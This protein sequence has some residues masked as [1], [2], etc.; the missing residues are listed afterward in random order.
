M[1]WIL[2]WFFKPLEWSL[3]PT[4]SWVI[5]ALHSSAAFMPCHSPSHSRQPFSSLKM[6]FFLPT[7]WPCY[8]SLECSLHLLLPN[9]ISFTCKGGVW[10]Q[11]QWTTLTPWVNFNS[12]KY[13]SSSPN[14]FTV[15]CGHVTRRRSWFSRV[16]MRS[17]IMISLSTLRS[18]S[19][20]NVGFHW[21]SSQLGWR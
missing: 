5:W 11:P 1:F 10:V 14:I 6:P 12:I 9:L 18:P 7:S 16:S 4:C 21:V 15:S 3:N 2:Q 13:S 8:L 20:C 19:L 17:N